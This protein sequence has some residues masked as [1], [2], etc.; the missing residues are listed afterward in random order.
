MNLTLLDTIN[1]CLDYMDGFRVSTIDDTIEA[2]QIASIAEKVFHDLNEDVFND[3]KLSNLVQL[4]SLA[5]STKPNYLK[6]PDSVSR[7]SESKVMYDISTNSD[8]RMQEI[9]YMPPEDFMEYIGSRGSDATTTTVTDFSGYK[10]VINND[11]MPKYYTDFDDT[12]LVFDSWDSVE[13]STLQGSKSGIITKV[14]RTWTTSDSYEIDLPDWFHSTYLNA[15][16]AEATMVLKEEPNMLAMKKARSGIIKGRKK[17]R[18]GTP[19][20]YR[21][22]YGRWA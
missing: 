16:I 20:R 22:N 15:V 1:Y 4:E 14:R 6:L 2:Q 10:M 7:I 17:Q 11:K 21:R 8:I 19:D 5:D 18:I 12:Y 13:E 9:D 3:E